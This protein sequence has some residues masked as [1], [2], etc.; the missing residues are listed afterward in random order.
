MMYI[1]D[2]PALVCMDSNSVFGHLIASLTY[3]NSNQKCRRTVH[4]AFHRPKDC[5]C[6]FLFLLLPLS[7]FFLCCLYFLAFFLLAFFFILPSHFW[8][9]CPPVSSSSGS[10]HLL[11]HRQIGFSAWV[12]SFQMPPELLLSLLPLKSLQFTHWCW[13]FKLEN[14]ISH[15]WKC[16]PRELIVHGDRVWQLLSVL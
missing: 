3:K 10:I 14:L 6:L 9:S 12:S 8:S 15:G 4:V 7:P 2:I 13:G 1:S 5:L 16:R 11:H